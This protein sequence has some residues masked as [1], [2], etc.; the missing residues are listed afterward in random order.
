M[1]HTHSDSNLVWE[2]I[3]SREDRA[4]PLFSVKVNRNRSPRTGKIHEFQVL[5][6]PTWVVVIPVTKDGHVIMVRQYRHGTGEL[7]LEPPGGL[8]KDGQT[9]EQSGREELEE[10]TGYEPG[11]VE[12]LGWMHPMPAL[13]GNRMY[14]FLAK[15][16][17]PT[18][19]INPD[20]TEEVETVRIPVREVKDYIRS[21]KITASVMI[22]ALHLFFDYMERESGE[23]A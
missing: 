1:D 9:P 14:V 4:Y 2:L 16:V 15:D 21:G 18:G 13:F 7:S 11:E 5:T 8:V 23:E 3:D 12:L 6:S 10:E 17:T 22:A 20:E 19:T